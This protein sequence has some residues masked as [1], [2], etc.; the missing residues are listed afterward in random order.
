MAGLRVQAEARNGLC[1]LRV[2][3]ELDLATAGE[4]AEAADR[5]LRAVPGSVV[6]NL[7]GLTFIDLRGAR[8]LAAV[9]RT[10]PA[11]RQVVV[12]SCPPYVRLLLD[13]LGPA[14]NY[15]P[16]DY[17]PADKWTVPQSGT[18]HLVNRVREARLHAC[19]AKLDA[20]AVLARLTDNS[21]RLANTSERMDLTRQ[22]GQRTLASARA[23]REHIIHSRQENAP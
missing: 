16:A 3:G 2:S 18:L 7:S 12:C 22:Q 19:V 21:I 11:G 17:L 23:A 4:F 20:R 13:A 1:V 15:L 6:V 10:V 8:T 14:L 5:A 9:I